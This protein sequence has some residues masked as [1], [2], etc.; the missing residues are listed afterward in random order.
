MPQS[1][2]DHLALDPL[3]EA[4]DLHLAAALGA[5]Q[6]VRL[7]CLPAFALSP[8][9]KNVRMETKSMS[10]IK[11]Q[12]SQTLQILSVNVFEKIPLQEGL[13]KTVSQIRNTESHQRLMRWNEY[14]GGSDLTPAPAPTAAGIFAGE[15]WV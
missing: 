2:F 4:D 9:D 14:S 3:D 10:V 8:L 1:L 6:G 7:H 13:T 15:L 12:M 5:A 11:Q